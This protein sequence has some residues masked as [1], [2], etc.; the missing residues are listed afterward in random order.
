MH[1]SKAVSWHYA[2]G[3]TEE[4]PVFLR[5]LSLHAQLEL[6]GTKFLSKAKLGSRT[7]VCAQLTTTTKTTT[8]YPPIPFISTH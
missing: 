2:A 6:A 7:F 8:P 5:L 1:L 3:S 4:V